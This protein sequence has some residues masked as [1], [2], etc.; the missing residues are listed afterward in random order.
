[1]FVDDVFS[2]NHSVIKFNFSRP[3]SWIIWIISR[4]FRL[5]SL[6][7]IYNLLDD[8]SFFFIGFCIL[9][10]NSLGLFIINKLCTNEKEPIL[11]FNFKNFAFSMLPLLQI[12]FWIFSLQYL[13]PQR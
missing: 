12:M 1:M 9:F 2:L 5:I 4:I 7:G 11:I 6:F 13:E 3:T 8:T 10:S